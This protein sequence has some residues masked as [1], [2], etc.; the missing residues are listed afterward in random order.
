MTRSNL[1]AELVLEALGRHLGPQIDPIEAAAMAYDA[2]SPG[3]RRV[4]RAV[5][6]AATPESRRRAS[7]HL[8]AAR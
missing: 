2:M 3:E 8:A 5:L 7:A 6:A 4:L 1:D